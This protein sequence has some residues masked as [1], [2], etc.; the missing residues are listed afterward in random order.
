MATLTGTWTSSCEATGAKPLTSTSSQLILNAEVERYKSG[1]WKF[2]A[3]A[4]VGGDIVCQ[5]DLLCAL[6]KK[7]V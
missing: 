1:I 4:T 7:E 5:A 6:R 2:K 3:F